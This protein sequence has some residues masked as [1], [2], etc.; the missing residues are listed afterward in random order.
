MQDTFPGESDML[1]GVTKPLGE[2]RSVAAAR[3]KGKHVTIGIRTLAITLAFF[4]WTSS[5]SAQTRSAR[6]FF[7]DGQAAY[8]QG[9]YEAAIESWRQAYELDP[10][11]ALQFNLAQA[12]GRLGRF[13]EERD[14]LRSYVDATASSG[15]PYDEG[16]MQSARARLAA[17]D[18]RLRRTGV[19][20]LGVPDDARVLVDGEPQQLDAS[21]NIPL[22]T[23]SHTIRV[24]REGYEEFDATIVVRGGEQLTIPVR[25][26]EE[27]AVVAAAPPR[28]PGPGV[29][30]YVTWGAAGAA[31]VTGSVLGVTASNRADGAFVGTRDA[32]SAKRLALGADL[33]FGATV[34]LAATGIVLWLVADD[35]EAP[36]TTALPFFEPQSGTA[37]F[38]LQS[39]F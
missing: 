33:C 7:L 20:L 39:S 22:T 12:Y 24:E 4:V 15:Q 1:T 38:V 14:A 8:Q 28:R 13:E 19:V 31:L 27:T 18:D 10:R 6:D 35:E 11:P 5:A 21:G 23:G 29:G 32:D 37:G 34:A 30:S 36:V 3:A 26:E 25:M 2:P 17:I 9:N 16:Q